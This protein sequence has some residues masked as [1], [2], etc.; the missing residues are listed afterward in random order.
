MIINTNKYE[1][2]EQIAKRVGLSVGKLK[3]L[4]VQP[5]LAF[6]ID[7]IKY[8][9]LGFIPSEPNYRMLREQMSLLCEYAYRVEDRCDEII[10]ICNEDLSDEELTAAIK[11]CQ[12]IFD[13]ICRSANAVRKDR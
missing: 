13:R 9:E 6:T 12:T 7:G 2:Y 5:V 8:Y 4:N 3:K 1:T 11:K 10:N